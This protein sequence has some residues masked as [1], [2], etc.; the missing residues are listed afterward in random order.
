MTREIKEY[1]EKASKDYQQ[2]SKIPIVIHY[3]NAAP[4]EDELQ[5]LGDIK[6]KNVLDIGCGGAQ[7]GI[8]M[9]KQGAKV[10]GIDI[11]L[12][13][14][15][16]ARELVE[17]NKVDIQLF[18]GDIEK[19][20]QIKSSSQDLVFSTWAL[21]YVDDLKSCF[22]EVYRVLKRNGDFV[23]A[24]PHPF[25]RT[26][27]PYTLKLRESYFE[28]GKIEEAEIL[29]DGQELTSIV[30]KRTIS[31]I[32]NTLLATGFSIER[33]IEPDSRVRYEKDPWYNKW[34]CT[35]E[36]MQYIPPTLIFKAKKLITEDR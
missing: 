32:V 29:D 27:D 13:Q 22:S 9:A 17:E 25:F 24:V 6:G 10:I 3:G 21:L 26:V 20:P 18:Q 35:P 33:L 14:L 7:C 36:L 19:L 34:G 30:Y 8:A 11:S 4:F 28:T 2:V 23:A 31:E 15:A 1:W 12:E 5:L 16:F